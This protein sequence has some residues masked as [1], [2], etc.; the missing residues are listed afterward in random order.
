MQRGDLQCLGLDRRLERCAR[1]RELVVLLL[2]LHDLG[3]EQL[4]VLGRLHRQSLGLGERGLRRLQLL[5]QPGK[6]GVELRTLR[7]ERLVAADHT[8][9]RRRQVGVE[10]V[11]AFGQ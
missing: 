5:G 9:G 4:G 3:V 1:L 8:L 6:L 2:Q 11:H 7:G 10:L